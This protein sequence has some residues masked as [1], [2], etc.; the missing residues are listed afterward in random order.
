MH[1][2]KRRQALSEIRITDIDY[3]K[4]KKIIQIILRRFFLKIK[5]NKKS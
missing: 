1:I 4:V 5:L 3:V 2:A